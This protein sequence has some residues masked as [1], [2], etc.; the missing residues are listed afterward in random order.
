MSFFQRMDGKMLECAW[1]GDL[2]GGPPGEYV[3]RGGVAEEDGGGES[4]CREGE[5]AVSDSGGRGVGVPRRE[6][7][8]A[9]VCQ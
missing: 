1:R 8:R 6:T 7:R 3:L 5:D 4:S 2:R 9:M